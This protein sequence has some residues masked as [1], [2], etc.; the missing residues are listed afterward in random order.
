MCGKKKW[1]FKGKG[2]INTEFSVMVLLARWD[3]NV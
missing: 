1:H 3:G 2:V